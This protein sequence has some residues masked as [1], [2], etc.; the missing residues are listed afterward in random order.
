MYMN[1]PYSFVCPIHEQWLILWTTF[2]VILIMKLDYLIVIYFIFK[3]SKKKKINAIS[4]I[5]SIDI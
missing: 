1:V 2:K 3:N 4:F 5:R